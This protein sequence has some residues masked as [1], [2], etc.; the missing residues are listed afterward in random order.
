M[1]AALVIALAAGAG[2]AVDVLVRSAQIT[3]ARYAQWALGDAATARIQWFG[4]GPAQQTPRADTALGGGEDATLAEV[5]DMLDSLLPVDSERT[6]V[7][8]AA[9]AIRSGTSLTDGVLAAEGLITDPLLSGLLT[10]WTGALPEQPGEASLSRALAERL[11]VTVGNTVEARIGEDDEFTSVQIVGV[12]ENNPLAFDVA[13]TDGTLIPE[14]P[15]LLSGPATVWFVDG[16]DLSWSDV[17]AGNDAGFITMSRTVILDPPSATQV[18]I[19][20]DGAAYEADVT[21][22]IVI[23]AVTVVSVGGTL[24]ALLIGPVFAIGARRSRRDY[25]LLRAQGAPAKTIR[26]IMLRSA[27]LVGLTGAVVGALTGMLAAI[28]TVV[29]TTATGSIA[30]PNLTLPWLDVLGI[31]LGGT[32]VAV[33][34]AWLPARRATRDDPVLALR[35]EQPEPAVSRRTRPILVAALLVASA[36]T[37]ALTLFTG[38]RLWLMVTGLSGTI[39]IVLAL[40]P[41]LPFLGRLAGRLPLNARIAVRDATRRADRTAPAV[42]GVAAAIAFALCVAIV[43]ATQYATASAAWALRAAPGTIMIYDGHYMA[44]TG[45]ENP[46]ATSVQEGDAGGETSV[47]TAQERQRLQDVI[48]EF[49]PETELVDV[50]MLSLE[51]DQFPRILIDPEKTCPAWADETETYNHYTDRPTGTGYPASAASQNCWIDKRLSDANSQSYWTTNDGGNIVVD[52]DGTLIRALGLPG[53]EEAAQA[54]EAGKIVLTRELDLWPDGTAHLGIMEDDHPAMAKWEQLIE[55]A[56][57]QGVYENPPDPIENATVI[58]EAEVFDWPSAQWQAFIP[59]SLLAKAPLSQN[60][61]TAERVGLIAT[62]N[63]LMDVQQLDQLRDRLLL[64][65]VNDITQARGY[66]NDGLA[67]TLTTVT[68]LAALIA[69]AATW[70][71][72]RLAVADMRPDLRVLSDVGASPRARR[73]IATALALTIGLL[74]TLAGTIAGVLLG[75]TA[76]AATASSDTIARG[77]WVLTVP[78]LPVAIIAVLIPALTAAATWLQQRT[79]ID[80]GRAADNGI[81]LNH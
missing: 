36:A 60:A 26:A 65:G 6:A 27:G 66:A 28:I 52:D 80:R 59:E 49:V 75:T 17:L 38:Q 50:R 61:P 3:D 12:H 24:I 2:T 11:N 7:R 14:A 47:T 72:S 69:F 42:T 13:L 55:D 20:L 77:A 21:V 5:T 57:G 44:S 30:Y 68:I 58:A 70:G 33:L 9:V 29:T 39:G 10:P 31:V 53:A 22:G 40:R 67:T 79:G 48:A 71:T 4:N 62:A 56:Q 41:L 76:A 73:R 23:V 46:F 18:P 34:S 15:T 81:A 1:L 74:G 64:L 51:G 19:Y 63:G 78:W 54:L 25:A 32:I 37:A 45:S 16:A 43:T 8:Q 35:G